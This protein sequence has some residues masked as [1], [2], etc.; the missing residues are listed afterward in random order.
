MILKEITSNKLEHVNDLLLKNKN[1]K[2]IK[3]LK[4]I[5]EEDPSNDDVWLFLGIAYRRINELERAI[6]CFKMSTEFNPTKIESWG[7]LVVTYLDLNQDELAKKVL[8][9]ACEKNPDDPKLEFY[10]ENLIYVYKKFGPF[11]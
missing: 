8:I 11:F 1:R 5:L 9:E 4:D 7:L 6:H 3:I 10:K 2:A